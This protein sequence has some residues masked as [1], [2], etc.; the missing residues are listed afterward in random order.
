MARRRGAVAD[1]AVSAWSGRR[2]LVT[3]AGGF[4][5]SWLASRLVEEGAEVACL[6]YERHRRRPSNLRLTGALDAV[7]P[8]W[9][10][11]ADPRSVDRAV[12]GA[13]TVFHL[14]AQPIVG[15]ANESPVGTFEANVLGTWTL[16]ESC[17]RSDAVERVVVASS[18]KAYGDQERLP[19]TED[20][21]LN[22][23]YPYDASKACTDILARSYARTYGMAVAVTRMANIYGGGDFNLSRI[24]PG[25]IVS[26][27]RGERPIVRSDGTPVR[28]YMHVD[29]AVA[30]FLLL[31]RR[32]HEAGVAGEAF[33][34]GTNTPVSV[35]ELVER[36]LAAT[37]R[38]ELEPTI[39]SPTKIHGE[40][41]RQFLDSAKAGRV[42]GWEAATD[43]DEGL[44]RSVEWYARHLELVTAA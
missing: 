15:V 1:V 3:G 23:L 37:G 16:L 17:R 19:Y 12:A 31:G 38:A 6:L 28:D 26:A 34:F 18:D 21:P 11:L 4:V 43:L 24:I 30:A 13:D 25:T 40:I 22:G 5:G 27:L 8:V 14:G 20:M 36:I 9:G 35:L 42:L 2:V 29:D 7:R 39:L 33:N 32:A 41:D 10:D 44:A